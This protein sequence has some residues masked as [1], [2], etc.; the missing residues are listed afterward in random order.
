[1]SVIG[2]L[3]VSLTA[4]SEQFVTGIGKA[5]DAVTK[6]VG[7]IPG[8][9][10]LFSKTG[11]IVGAL[12]G[13]A[14]AA[15][16]QHQAALIDQTAK[17]ADRIGT[18][19]EKLVGLQ[20][21]GE[22]AGGGAEQINDALS[23]LAK[24]L[25]AAE[26]GAGS[27]RAGLE[28]LGLGIGELLGKDPAEQ[29][30]IVADAISKLSTQEEKAAA[31]ASLF[32][33]SGND[34]VNVLELGRGGLDAMQADAEKLGLTFSRLD[35]AKVEQANDALHRVGGVIDGALRSAVI[36]LAPYIEA[37]A[38][39][40]TSWAT[41]GEGAGA[42]VTA[43]IGW[44][45]DAI[46]KVSGVMQFLY[47]TGKMLV[48]SVG[49]AF[50][51]IEGSIGEVVSTLA[52]LV[53]WIPGLD[54]KFQWVDDWSKSQEERHAAMASIEAD[55]E[56]LIQTSDELS[57]KTTDWFDRMKAGAQQAAAATAAAAEEKRKLAAVAGPGVAAAEAEAAAAEKK[58]KADATS[59][60]SLERARA[61]FEQKVADAERVNQL[62]E[63]D[64]KYASEILEI[65]HARAQGW[66][67]LADRMA[68]AL[69]T[70]QVADALDEVYKKLDAQQKLVDSAEAEVAKRERLAE[71]SKADREFGSEILEIEDARAKGWTDLA[72]RMEA[73]LEKRR[74][75]LALTK[76]QD[77]LEAKR[78]AA[79]DEAERKAKAGADLAR[80]LSRELELLTAANDLER[81]RVRIQQEL[82]DNMEKAAGNLAAQNAAQEV[83][84]LKL[85]AVGKDSGSSAAAGAGGRSGSG[86]GGDGG[87]AGGG[88]HKA[89]SRKKK[90]RWGTAFSS[91]GAGVNVAPES[92]FEAGQTR[93]MYNEK[94][95]NADWVAV[96][97]RKAA[98][99]A[100]HPEARAGAAASVAS[101]VGGSPAAAGG[102]VAPGGGSALPDPS[103]GIKEATAAL[104]EVK[105][106]LGEMK[107]ATEAMGADATDLAAAVAA[108]ATAIAASQQKL[109]DAVAETKSEL[110]HLKDV[111]D[112]VNKA[113]GG[114]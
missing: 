65:E 26:E 75:E 104:G 1:M 98:W 10:A 93:E 43:A 19:T 58:A 39:G 89:G 76:Q 16:A 15:L 110:A 24:G 33:K 101:G 68:E 25:G 34:L 105:A 95:R 107:T 94:K 78:K 14:F 106:K 40:F 32:G 2:S 62:S 27:A 87:D 113:I 54:G 38:N 49:Q 73:L 66:T 114:S 92:V 48:G 88:S 86:D 103:P 46:A 81:E 61:S 30:R 80:S 70:E 22:L 37:L 42:K 67:E 20:H 90:H 72:D 47:G 17:L 9:N 60:A 97:D 112:A 45:A 57:T 99:E 77:A 41:E 36:S 28:K 84:A 111:L 44:V 3:A 109:G 31:A 35:A 51:E 12:A 50:V 5:S 4:K 83:A 64:K 96:L 79:A 21:A 69:H 18:S 102:T 23:K 74:A 82:A 100:A 108:S 13:G 53:R 71:L 91:F 29:F 63:R 6:F 59:A 52:D 7:Q 85:A 56:R 55:G 11:A 8:L